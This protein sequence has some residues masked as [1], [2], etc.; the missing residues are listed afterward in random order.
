MTGQPL[1][2]AVRELVRAHIPG[3]PAIQDDTEL[4]DSGL[5]DSLGIVSVI[6]T[7]QDT[8]VIDFP[9][10]VLA[11]ETFQTPQALTSAVA[12][13]IGRTVEHEER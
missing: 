5:L 1:G 7:L 3:R 12:V 10:E 6:S 9:P 8:Y 13:L 11:P 2:A 4:L